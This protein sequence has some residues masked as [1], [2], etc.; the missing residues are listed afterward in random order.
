M[1][2][3]SCGGGASPPPTREVVYTDPKGVEHVVQSETEAKIQV[4]VNGGGSYS[5]RAKK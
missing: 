4:S 1:G 5:V 3:S 2:C